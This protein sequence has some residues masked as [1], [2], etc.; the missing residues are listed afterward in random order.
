MITLPKENEVGLK[1]LVPLN[2]H[3]IAYTPGVDGAEPTTCPP[4][5]TRFASVNV[6]APAK[7]IV[8]VPFCTSTGAPVLANENVILR[9]VFGGYVLAQF[10][11]EQLR[12]GVILRTVRTIGALVSQPCFGL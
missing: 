5:A 4:C 2:V 12:A 6:V 11:I 1:E 3:E 7:V 8:K 9:G 10:P